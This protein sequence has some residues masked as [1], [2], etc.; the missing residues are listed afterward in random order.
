MESMFVVDFT[1]DVLATELDL[2]TISQSSAYPL[3]HLCR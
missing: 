1:H 2:A 3:S